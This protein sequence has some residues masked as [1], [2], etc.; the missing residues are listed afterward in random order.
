MPVSIFHFDKLQNVTPKTIT[1]GPARWSTELSKSILST[2]PLLDGGLVLEPARTNL[3]ANGDLSADY[4]S[5]V[6]INKNTGVLTPAGGKAA[7]LSSHLASAVSFYLRIMGILPNINSRYT[8]GAFVKPLAPDTDIGFR[9]LDG[10]QNVACSLF[11]NAASDRIWTEVY[12]RDANMQYKVV[13]LKDGWYWVCISFT[14]GN[15]GGIYID[16]FDFTIGR[17]GN[18]FAESQGVYIGGIVFAAGDGFI[19]PINTS[20]SQVTVAARQLDI[21]LAP[22][23]RMLFNFEP[24]PLNRTITLSTGQVVTLPANSA[25]LIILSNTNN[26]EIYDGNSVPV[27]HSPIS[28]SVSNL[29]MTTNCRLVIKNI[30]IYSSKTTLAELLNV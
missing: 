7:L 1:A 13:K 14:S 28:G 12:G 19:N 17:S 26:L 25:Q 29:T 23:F 8:V 27:T 2:Q 30:T 18:N 10:G 15:T 3:F 24:Y 22:N 9:W 5:Y 11:L 6:K 21:P 20:G 16:P 4:P